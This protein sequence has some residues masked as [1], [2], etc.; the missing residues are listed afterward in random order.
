MTY[1]Q[2]VY[3]SVRKLEQSD[4]DNHNHT[5]LFY[6]QSMPVE[7]ANKISRASIHL[8]LYPYIDSYVTRNIRSTAF[9]KQVLCGV[10]SMDYC[11][12]Y[13]SVDVKGL[14]MDRGIESHISYEDKMLYSIKKCRR[15]RTQVA[16]NTKVSISCQRLVSHMCF[17]GYRY[18]EDE[19]TGI[20]RTLRSYS[21]E[22]DSFKLKLSKIHES[23]LIDREQLQYDMLL[24]ILD[25]ILYGTPH[26]CTRN[27]NTIRAYWNMDDLSK[28]IPEETLN[29]FL[30]YHFPHVMK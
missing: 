8:A 2:S 1:I 17:N 6:I 9:I 19:S 21:S 18:C 24:I 12:L 22:V 25:Y 10:R 7:I 11:D 27:L 28:Y 23:N 3:N 20:G 26:P 15:I 13:T 14:Q 29:T 5:I 30:I 4:N 16:F